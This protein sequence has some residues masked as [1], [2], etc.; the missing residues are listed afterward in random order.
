LFVDELPEPQRYGRTINFVVR[1]SIPLFFEAEATEAPEMQWMIGVR[2]R[3]LSISATNT[4]D[5]RFWIFALYGRGGD[6][7]LVAIPA[8]LLGYVLGHSSMTWRMPLKSPLPP[9][10]KITLIGQ[11]EEGP[12]HVQAEVQASQ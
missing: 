6:G 11:S 10:H 1:H 5:R 8:G 2:G 12:F 4:G 9:F 3:T 7:E